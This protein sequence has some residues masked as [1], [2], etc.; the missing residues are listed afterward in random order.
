[1]D[2]YNNASQSSQSVGDSLPDLHR[3]VEKL[4]QRDTKI[5]PILEQDSITSSDTQVRL[6]PRS[7]LS[8]ISP[9]MSPY[10]GG[11]P[12]SYAQHQQRKAPST[13]TN[14]DTL[15]L[16]E[17]LD[18]L[19]LAGGNS[20][21]RCLDLRLVGQE[22]RLS[23]SGVE[24]RQAPTALLVTTESSDSNNRSRATY[25]SGSEVLSNPPLS[26]IS[27]SLT[28]DGRGGSTRN[29]HGSVSAAVSDESVAGD[30]GVFEASNKR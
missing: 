19:R 29:T 14:F 7:S 6:S 3:R 13:G 28:D 2:I 24:T 26:P 17:Q 30:S 9:P 5:P 22:L 27:E 18:E 20:D 12:P 11:P 10:E 1:M 25:D 8:S 15:H 21:G 23:E 4:L 16:E